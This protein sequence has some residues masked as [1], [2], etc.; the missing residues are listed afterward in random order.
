MV[1]WTM[2]IPREGSCSLALRG[3]LMML[4]DPMADNSD[5]K[6]ISICFTPLY[7]EMGKGIINDKRITIRFHSEGAI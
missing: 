3:M 6:I 7:K 1:P 5:V 4:R 2:T